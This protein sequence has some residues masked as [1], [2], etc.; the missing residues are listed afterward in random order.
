MYEEGQNSA[1]LL[2]NR[3]Y[4]GGYYQAVPL[5]I[6]DL[7]TGLF[8]KDLGIG[9]RLGLPLDQDLKDFFEHLTQKSYQDLQALSS[10]I[11]LSKWAYDT[12]DCRNFVQYL[13]ELV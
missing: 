4:E 9:V 5:V 6:A 13:E 1:W 11:P 7:E 3:L 12:N 10:A 8:T 2:P